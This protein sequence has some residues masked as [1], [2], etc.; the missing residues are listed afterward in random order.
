MAGGGFTTGMSVNVIP[1]I[2]K[3]KRVSPYAFA[4][5][6][7]EAAKK[8]IRFTKEW[9]KDMG[10]FKSVG[11]I[12][13]KEDRSGP[14]TAHILLIANDKT[15]TLYMVLFEGPSASWAEIWKIAEPMLN[16]LF[17]DDTI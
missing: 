10:P 14:F 9:D 7:R 11:F 12:Y 8:T 15:G 5:Q 1:N 2:P 3:K 4:H 17:I 13:T 16:F 6:Y